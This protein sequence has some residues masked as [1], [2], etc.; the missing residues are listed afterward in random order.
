MGKPQ[1]QLPLQ[2]DDEVTISSRLGVHG[3]V[4]S[5]IL[6]SFLF[7]ECPVASRFLHGT[8]DACGH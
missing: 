1:G 5:R 2:D 7:P 6:G 3:S 8:A 4:E